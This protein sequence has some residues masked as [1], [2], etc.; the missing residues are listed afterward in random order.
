M[1]WPPVPPEAAPLEPEPPPEPVAPPDPE[2]PSVVDDPQ[3]AS[4]NRKMPTARDRGTQVYRLDI[5]ILPP[6]SSFGA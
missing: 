2:T 5:M 4:Q 3:A 6:S 1:L